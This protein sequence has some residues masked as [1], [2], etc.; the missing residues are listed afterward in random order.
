[1]VE[2]MT[3]RQVAEHLGTTIT[4]VNRWVKSDR[5]KPSQTVPG[6]NGARLFDPAVVEEFREERGQ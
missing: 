6:Y 4:T 1:M 5:L 3:S 2:L